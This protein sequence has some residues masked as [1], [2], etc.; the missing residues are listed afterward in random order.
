[1][2]RCLEQDAGAEDAWESE[3]ERRIEEIKSG[4]AQGVPAAEVF[5][6]LRE[7]HS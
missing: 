7:K 6:K 1:M 3:L 4:K 2:K 5:V